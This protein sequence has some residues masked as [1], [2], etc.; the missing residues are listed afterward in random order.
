MSQEKDHNSTLA[1]NFYIRFSAHQTWINCT[2]P[3]TKSNHTNKNDTSTLLPCARPNEFAVGMQSLHCRR[4]W[5]GTLSCGITCHLHALS[6]HIFCHQHYSTV[7]S[8]VLLFSVTYNFPL[9]FFQQQVACIDLLTASS[10]RAL[11]LCGTIIQWHNITYGLKHQTQTFRSKT[12]TVHY[13]LVWSD[14][15]IN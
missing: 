14:S 6:K 11:L 12:E 7:H 13:G 2:I 15:F 5:S 1:W 9:Y 10:L 3:R 8:I 4:I